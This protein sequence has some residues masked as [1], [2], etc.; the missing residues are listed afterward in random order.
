VGVEVK[1]ANRTITVDDAGR[2]FVC[3]VAAS[4]PLKLRISVAGVVA[5]TTLTP[6]E[7]SYTIVDWRPWQV[8]R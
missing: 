8:R 7:G 6:A 3:K 4:R 2:F 5:D 1:T